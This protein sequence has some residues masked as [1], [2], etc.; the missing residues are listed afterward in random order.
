MDSSKEVRRRSVTGKELRIHGQFKPPEENGRKKLLGII[1]S[2]RRAP[3]VRVGLIFTLS[4]EYGFQPCRKHPKEIW[5]F[6]LC[7][8]GNRGEAGV[9][10]LRNFS[11]RIILARKYARRSSS[12]WYA[13][14]APSAMA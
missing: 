10:I 14:W 7:G 9:A 11:S 8:Q 3:H 5:G 12:N 6:S 13:Q 4:G 1:E 2:C